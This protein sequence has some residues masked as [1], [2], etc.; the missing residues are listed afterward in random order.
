MTPDDAIA[1]LHDLPRFAGVADDA[2]RP[3]LERMEA[4]MDAM[5]RPHEAFPSVHVAGTN[6]KGSTASMVAAIITAA[7]ERTGLHTSPHLAHVTERMRIDG[8]PAPTEW[9]ADA[10]TRHRDAFDRIGPSFF[11]ATVALSFLYFAEQTVDRAV[12]EVGLGGRLDATNILQPELAVITSIDLEHTALLGDTLTAIAREKAGIIKLGVPVLTAVRQPEALDAIRRVARE[13]EATLHVLDA[14][15]DV[16]RAKT[17]LDH[18]VLNIT[19]PVR[20]YDDLH[21]DLGGVHQQRNAL[22]AARA[23]EVLGLGADAIRTGLRDVRRLSSLRGRLELLQRDPLVVADV[24]HNPSSLAATLDA[25]RPT[26]DVHGGRLYMLLGL[27]RDKDVGAIAELLDAA[28][29]IVTPVALPSERALPAEALRN[30][31]AEHGVQAN[32]P[33]TIAAGI[34]A[35]QQDAAADDV[36]LIT[37]SHQMVESLI[38]NTNG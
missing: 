4:L 24:A 10:V 33:S 37:G 32:G 25:V 22:L 3:G 13:R 15:V 20:A 19:S 34:A 17:F 21:I 14:D 27:M 23:A 28:H 6:G 38:S 11:E 1:Y 31:L 30:V 9:L 2:Y 36:L 18:S 35:F 8:A 7:G 29:A 12:V 16:R 26:L 5:N